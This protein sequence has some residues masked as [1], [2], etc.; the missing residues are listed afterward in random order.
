MQKLCFGPILYG[1]WVF[2][3]FHFKCYITW[4][5]WSQIVTKRVISWNKPIVTHLWQ[6]ALVFTVHWVA[7][8]TIWIC[9]SLINNFTKSLDNNF[10]TLN[11]TG[12]LALFFKVCLYLFWHIKRAFSALGSVM[13]LFFSYFAFFNLLSLRMI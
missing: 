11:H 1:T 3:G 4:F 5:V 7:N 13:S 12:N 9:G 10:L 8:F 2:Y 6:N